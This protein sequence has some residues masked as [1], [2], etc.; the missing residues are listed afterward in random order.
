M[1]TVYVKLNEQNKIVRCDTND[2]YGHVRVDVDD[3]MTGD[4]L[5]SSFYI[6]GQIKFDA[7]DYAKRVAKRR[8]QMNAAKQRKLDEEKLKNIEMKYRLASLSDEDAMSVMSLFPSWDKDAKY[9]KDE[10]VVYSDN[11]YRVLNDTN[12]NSS[13]PDK[14]KSFYSVIR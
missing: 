6:D 7:D 8:E 5:M 10:R 9:Q 3:D 13:T 4:K 11:L 1:K 2:I 12:G 14:N